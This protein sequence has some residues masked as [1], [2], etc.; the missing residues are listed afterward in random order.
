MAGPAP[1]NGTNAETTYRSAR[2]PLLVPTWVM[3]GVFLVLPVALMAV[4]SFLTKEMR[5]GVIWEFSF[6]AYDQFFVNRGL[7]GDEPPSLEW[8]Y[9]GVFG[10]SIAQ[11]TVA[12]TLCLV[13]GFPTAWFIATRAP[14]TR[15]VWLFLITVP[16]W[17]NLLIRTVSLRFLIRENGPLN[18]AL[19]GAGLISQPLALINTNFAVQLGLFYSYLP[20]MVLPIYAAVERYNFA[21]S[22]AAA[23]L[24]ASR[25]VTLREI[26]L[27][28]VKPGIIAGCLLVFIPSLGAFLAPNLLGGAKNFMIGSLIEE[29]FKKSLGNWPFGAAVSMILMSLVLILLLLYAR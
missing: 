10:R 12:T 29:Q 1:D 26:V 2:V 14:A 23:D 28:I 3:I 8:T 24:Y 27:P 7:F 19:M 9:I 18:D 16:Y 21:L 20:F 11:A 17:V 6:A 25:W 13:I 15:G 5:G 22:E 4:Y